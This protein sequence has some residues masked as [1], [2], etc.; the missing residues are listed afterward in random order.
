MSGLRKIGVELLYFDGCP[1]YKTALRDIREIVK[2]EGLDADVTL[3]R[4]ESEEEARQLRFVGSP[5]VRVNGADVE[6]AAKESKDFGLRCR[7]YRV[8]GRILGSP[9]KNMLKSALTRGLR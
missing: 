5:T 7:I 6:P 3:T 1:T 4:V 9:S 8:D 2:Q